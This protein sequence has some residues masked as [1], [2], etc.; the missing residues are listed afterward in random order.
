MP[1]IFSPFFLPLCLSFVC[2]FVTEMTPHF[3]SFVGAIISNGSEEVVWFWVV[4]WKCLIRL[5]L[6]N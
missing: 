2:A 1:T 6:V 3:V 4:N 5:R